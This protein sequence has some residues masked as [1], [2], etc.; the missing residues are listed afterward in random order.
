MELYLLL[1]IIALFVGFC[2]GFILGGLSCTKRYNDS[3]YDFGFVSGY[4]V[5]RSDFY[6]GEKNEVPYPRS[7]DSISP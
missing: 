2:V 4:E 7:M 5:A 6:G 3:F 1:M